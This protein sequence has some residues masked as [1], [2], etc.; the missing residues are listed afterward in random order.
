MDDDYQDDDNNNS[1]SGSELESLRDGTEEAL[2]WQ[3]SPDC[4]QIKV[5]GPEDTDVIPRVAGK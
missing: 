5:Y 1:G 3:L 2:D 4:G